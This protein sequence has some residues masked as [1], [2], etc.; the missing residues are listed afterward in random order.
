MSKKYSLNKAINIVELNNE[1][2]VE[3]LE[4]L[5]NNSSIEKVIT[6]LRFEDEKE[7]MEYIQQGDWRVNG[8][9]NVRRV[10]LGN[11]LVDP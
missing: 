4:I 9:E 6:K 11:L 7:G 1:K 5:G 10:E 2:R 3:V 8:R